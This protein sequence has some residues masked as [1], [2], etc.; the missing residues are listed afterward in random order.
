MWVQ[1][2]QIGM[3]Y[4]SYALFKRKRVAEA[5]KLSPELCCFADVIVA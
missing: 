5:H 3:A 2:R 1:D 4:Q